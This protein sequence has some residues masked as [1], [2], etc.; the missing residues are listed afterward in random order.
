MKRIY[1]QAMQDMQRVVKQMNR[2]D[3]RNRRYT[4]VE[5]RKDYVQPK[6]I[7]DKLDKLE[8]SGELTGVLSPSL[9]S[10][11]LESYY[12][13]YVF[14]CNTDD[15][16]LTS[17]SCEEIKKDILL[18]VCNLAQPILNQVVKKF[19]KIPDVYPLIR[20]DI[21][22]D[23]TVTVLD[24]YRRQRFD[25]A[26]KTRLSSFLFELFWYAIL[27]VTTKH[28]KE[29]KRYVS[30]DPQALAEKVESAEHTN[31]TSRNVYY[32]D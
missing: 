6:D 7:T 32:D 13:E 24:V 19:K 31:S 26:R 14:L 2:R 5:Q 10:D 25:F 15:H 12:I 4:K 30:V 27:G 22:T 11:R 28:F 17:E 23:C 29:K 21:R 18:T 3:P 20:D 9:I 8:L 1:S 16:C